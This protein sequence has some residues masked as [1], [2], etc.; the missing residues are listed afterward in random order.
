MKHSLHQEKQK[1]AE[2][3]AMG[4]G[5]GKR[6]PGE[7]KPK[8]SY[9]EKDELAKRQKIEEYIKRLQEGKIPQARGVQGFKTQ[10]PKSAGFLDQ[11]EQKLRF[12]Q[13]QEQ[14]KKQAT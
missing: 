6:V 8:L 5:S 7:N 2:K 13:Y 12:Q 10:Q 1:Q 11:L 4:I 14:L 3:S 9:K